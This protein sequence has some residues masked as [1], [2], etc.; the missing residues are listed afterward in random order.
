MTIN[1]L[2][3]TF[4]VEQILTA[5]EMNQITDKIDEVIDNLP[6]VSEFITETKADEKYATKTDI[7]NIETILDNI[8]G[9]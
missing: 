3:K 6:N 7:G 8:I 5:D 1:K 4:V 2:D 9:G